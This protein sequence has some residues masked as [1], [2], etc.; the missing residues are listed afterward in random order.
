MFSV[1][2]CGFWISPDFK[3]IAAGVAIFLFGMMSL[4]EGFKVFTGG[5]LEKILSR[6]TNRLWKSL[7]FGVVTTSLMQS[8]SLVS[9]I[10]ISFLS[11]GLISLSAGIGIIFGANLG[12]TTG[13]WLVAAFGLK[14]N[15]AAY[16]MPM[17]VFG[18][19]LLFQK[20]RQLKGVGYILAG[21]GFL[22]LGIYYM[23]EGFDAFKDQL[24]LTAYA[25]SGYKGILLF[26]LIGVIA[27]VIMQSSHA[28]LVLIITALAA[29]QITYENALALAIGANLGTTITAII[30]AL[31]ANVDGRRLAGAHLIFNAVTAIIAI[32]FIYQLT[33]VVDLASEWLSIAPDNYTLKLAVFHTIFNAIGLVVMLPFIGK[34]ES[35]L[36]KAIHPQIRTAAQPRFLHKVSSDMPETAIESVRKETLH[37]YENAYD[38]IAGGLRLSTDDIRSELPIDEVIK[39]ARRPHPINIDVQY[40]ETIKT[41]YSDIVEYIS[42]LRGMSPSQM[43]EL[44]SYRAAGREIVEAIK[45][46][47]HLQKNLERYLASDNS[48]IRQEY[49]Q[50][51]RELAEVLREL[52]LTRVGADDDVPAILS[53]D[54]MRLR[55]KENDVAL[56]HRLE[57]LIRTRKVSPQQAT[58]LMNDSN[59]I[60]GAT[61]NLVKMGETLFSP[62]TEAIKQAEKML[63]LKDE[64]LDELVHDQ[65]ER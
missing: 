35:V 18:V 42:T 17:I 37:L 56:T 5:L 31:G 44:F 39:R 28:T 32:V 6:T 51:R 53:L 11:A 52:E 4:E 2:G 16:A 14:V 55:M 21:L 46:T 34:L 22:F 25:V 1:L 60:Y 20:S 12:T 23:K 47:K 3:E 49:N 50:L 45:N 41:L 61:K 8:S 59:Y 48:N 62:E 65:G 19:I 38:V 64:E 63:L 43:D 30:G 26:T 57:E 27:T 24:D 7:S 40:N 29:Q 15:I 10:T 58:S 13:A 9:I 33:T 36:I 54:A